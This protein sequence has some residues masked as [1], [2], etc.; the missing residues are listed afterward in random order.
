MINELSTNSLAVDGLNRALATR[1]INLRYDFRVTDELGG[2]WSL[3]NGAVM[4]R[5]RSFDLDGGT[6]KLS[7]TVLKARIP[8]GLT[9]NQYQ[10]IAVDRGVGGGLWAYFRGV[11]QSIRESTTRRGGSIVEVLNIE[12]EGNLSKLRG[13][14]ISR[15]SFSPATTDRFHPFIG[16]ARTIEYKHP[17]TS[18]SA[19]DVWSLAGDSHMYL[20]EVG[21]S[22]SG[23]DTDILTAVQVAS[24]ADFST[25]YTAGGGTADYHVVTNVFPYQI[26]WKKAIGPANFYVRYRVVDRWILPKVRA[27]NLATGTAT[28][29]I[30]LPAGHYLARQNGGGTMTL[31]GGPTGS[32]DG[33]EVAEFNLTATTSVTF[34]MSS[35]PAAAFEVINTRGREPY[36]LCNRRDPQNLLPT[37]IASV[38]VG[39]KFITP[40]DSA[41]YITGVSNLGSPLEPGLPASDWTNKEYLTVTF[42]D[43]AETTVEITAINRTTGQ[44]TVDVFPTHPT[45]GTNAAAGDRIRVST[46]EAVQAFA[47]RYP[48]SLGELTK[49]GTSITSL[50]PQ[51]AGVYYQVAQTI[52]FTGHHVGSPAA[53][54]ADLYWLS[55]SHLLA[56]KDVKDYEVYN[57]RLTGIRTIEDA[58]SLISAGGTSIVLSNK[59]EDWIRLLASYQVTVGPFHYNDDWVITNTGVFTKPRSR[60]ATYLD[61]VIK[62]IMA[63]SY[64]PNVLIR[65][66]VDGKISLGPVQQT[67]TP[68]YVLPGVA[69]VD[70]ADHSDRIT[71][72]TVV[73]SD[74]Q[75]DPVDIASIVFGGVSVEGTTPTWKNVQNI[76]DSKDSTKAEP[77]NVAG[78]TESFINTIW[79]SVPPKSPQ[80][81]Y[82]TIESIRISGT[83]LIIG[84]FHRR[85]SNPVTTLDQ[86]TL[87]AGWDILGSADWIPLQ[88]NQPFTIQGDE[89]T[90]IISSTD[91]S[92]IAISVRQITESTYSNA[93]I[94][95][96]EIMQR[97]VNAHTAMMTD[98][99]NIASNATVNAAGFGTVWS[100]PDSNAGIS[101]RYAPTAWI[102]RNS[103]QYGNRTERLIITNRGSGYTSAPTVS[104]A[105]GAKTDSATAVIKGGQVVMLL[106]SDGSARDWPGIPAVTISGGGGSGATAQAHIARPRSK[107]IRLGNMHQSECRTYAENYMDEYLRSHLVYTVQAPLL[108]YAEPGDTVLVQLPDGT[109]KALLLWG[110][111]DSGGPGDNMATYTLRDYSL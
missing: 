98:N 55:T 32:Y 30:S 91:Y 88:N 10:Q 94:T 18:V 38:N 45:L 68:Q 59:V 54:A 70:V 95:S 34:T 46:L 82:P 69:S 11:I 99:Q 67:T 89:L 58:V 39:S 83:G 19:T 2:V 105:S 111:T 92:N 44:M 6:W 57:S 102:K 62:E 22:T 61:E 73:A 12:C 107:I 37:T 110:I 85:T 17:A 7:L 33:F 78:K 109:Q 80:E 51:C 74:D 5:S 87:T 101:F 20:R 79:F 84:I 60:A 9:L 35:S 1:Q 106:T 21:G 64:P 100:Q 25:L 50:R 4:S 72:M 66:R 53:T 97:K 23:H 56:N 27:K 48:A 93:G 24:N 76:F 108:D 104:L 77:E 40:T 43:G 36:F 81:S 96:V 47:F 103:V 15:F 14:Y 52:P 28:Q 90:K 13:N 75:G 71:A 63:E 29:T 16:I 49:T 3:S 41:S 42:S 26:H 65:D 86:A 31:S 8:S